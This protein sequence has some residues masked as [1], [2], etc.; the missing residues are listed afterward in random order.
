MPG[1]AAAVFATNRIPNQENWHMLCG[2][3]QQRPAKV[4][5]TQ[6]PLGGGGETAGDG[7]VHFCEAC[8]RE[9]MEN[10]PDF[11]KAPFSQPVVSGEHRTLPCNVGQND[12]PE[13]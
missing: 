1:V 11:K 8:A 5:V 10:N 12:K 7:T 4:H 13:R 9:F 3:C 2:N 6:K